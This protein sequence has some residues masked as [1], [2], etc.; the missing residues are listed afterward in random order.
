MHGEEKKMTGGRAKGRSGLEKG[1]K[2]FGLLATGFSQHIGLYEL[3]GAKPARKSVR[4]GI[5]DGPP[6]PHSPRRRNQGQGATA[7]C[8]QDG[9]SGEGEWP[10]PDTPQHHHG[11]GRETRGPGRPPL[12]HQ[13][14]AEQRTRAGNAE[15]HEPPGTAPPAS[16]EGT[17]R[18]ARAKRQRE[19]G[20]R[21]HC[22]GLLK[23]PLQNLV[24]Y[25]ALLVFSLFLSL[26]KIQ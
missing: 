14:Q 17:S 3:Q 5:G 10:T 19:G 16:C 13:G 21:E 8:P 23:K 20:K 9:R 22:S 1:V 7:A 4:C 25:N 2:L 6:L 11:T 26:C 18:R 12:P 24:C 15:G